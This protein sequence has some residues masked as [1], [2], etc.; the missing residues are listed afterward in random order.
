MSS[1]RSHDVRLMTD[2]FFY[3]LRSFDLATITA[4]PV[5]FELSSSIHKSE[6]PSAL[7][8]PDEV[9]A[10]SSFK[11]LADSRQIGCYF[12]ALEEVKNLSYDERGKCRKH[13]DQEKI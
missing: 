9:H 3:I 1:E 11:F 10:T 8:S 12:D 5:L 7:V 6:A 13:S 4:L 2:S